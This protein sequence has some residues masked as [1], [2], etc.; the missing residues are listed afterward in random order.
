MR[1]RKVLRSRGGDTRNERMK[2]LSAFRGRVP[3]NRRLKETL[4]SARVLRAA[5][6]VGA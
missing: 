5:G 3:T 1:T 6:E 4:A 2:V